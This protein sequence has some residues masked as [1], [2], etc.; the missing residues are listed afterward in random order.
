MYEELI[1]LVSSGSVTLKKAENQVQFGNK[2]VKSA[3]L[4]ANNNI[5]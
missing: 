3:E 1:G 5:Q 4:S 2:A